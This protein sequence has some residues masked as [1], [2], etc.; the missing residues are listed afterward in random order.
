MGIEVK[1]LKEI[2]N[3]QIKQ[4]HKPELVWKGDK[5]NKPLFRFKGKYDPWLLETRHIALKLNLSLAE[6]ER[7]ILNEEDP[8]MMEFWNDYKL[9]HK[10]VLF[11]DAEFS[12]IKPQLAEFALGIFDKNETT[13][14]DVILK[15]PDMEQVDLKVKISRLEKEIAYYKKGG[16]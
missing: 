15:K 5:E 2:C 14:T 11:Y 3:N 7:A 6:L 8:A 13:K 10:Q 4:A 1:K 12:N 16:K 9:F